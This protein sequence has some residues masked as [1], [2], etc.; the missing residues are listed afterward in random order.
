[1][2]PEKTLSRL[3]GAVF[4]IAV[5]ASA[6][7]T[8]SCASR[9]PDAI[10]TATTALWIPAESVPPGET[11]VL[12]IFGGSA[13]GSTARVAKA[14]AEELHARVVS[15]EQAPFE[16]LGNYALVG[17]GSGIYDGKHHSALL[18][19][20]NELAPA[21]RAKA[22]LFSTCGIPARFANPEVLADQSR[23]NHA[24]LREKLLAKG[25][26]IVGEF[27]SLGFNNNSFLKLFGG[28]NKG[29]PNVDDIGNAAS[30]AK[31]L[32]RYLSSPDGGGSR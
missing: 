3:P 2:I 28:I 17:F 18:A 29:R 6:L 7:G 11:R 30:F 27:G 15:P 19:L 23:K 16:K 26:E 25:F 20:A 24:A 22:F 10:S 1:M 4:L 8:S 12:I 32:E 13:A 21:P 5:A 31:G 9:S 14:I